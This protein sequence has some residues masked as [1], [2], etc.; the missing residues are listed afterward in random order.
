MARRYDYRVWTP[1]Q[2]TQLLAWRAANPKAPWCEADGLFVGFTG[3]QAGS[4][5]AKL[6]RGAR[7]SPKLGRP[8][9]PLRGEHRFAIANDVPPEVIADAAARS[10]LAPASLTAAFFGD[11]LPGR[12]AL[13]QRGR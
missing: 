6:T 1:E 11:P 2:C 3:A 7:G 13:D 5:W 12:S 8:A 4:K 10:A 9:G